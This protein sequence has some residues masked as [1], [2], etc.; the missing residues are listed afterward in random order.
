MSSSLSAHDMHGEQHAL[1][2]GAPAQVNPPFGGYAISPLTRWWRSVAPLALELGGA[3]PHYT[4]AYRTWGR[5]A[6][7]GD[8]AVIVC[9]ALTGTADAD[10][11]WSA[12]FGPG[13]ALDPARDFI[14]CS[15]V[16]GGCYGSTGPAS[17]DVAPELRGARFPELTIRDQ[18]RAQM[19][20]ADALGVRRIRLVIGGSMGGLQ[21]LEW[22]LLDGERVDAIAVVAASA[23]HS[24]WCLA[25]CEIQRLALRA[26]PRFLEGHYT[27]DAMPLA[28]LG[29]ARA[30]AM[31]TYRSPLALEDRFGRNSTAAVY[32]TGATASDDFAVRAWVRHH[33]ENFVRRFD[34]N[35]YLRLLGAMDH[36]D[37]GAGRGGVAAA[38]ARVAQPALV[39]S[40]SSDLLYLPLEQEML[41]DALP[42]ARLLV[43]PS[44]RGHDGFLID[45]DRLEPA[46]RTFRGLEA[47][48][49]T[50]VRHVS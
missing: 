4:L 47:V 16:L 21:T 36:H 22:A 19:A 8:N 34:A 6:P 44:V 37:V 26:D 31:A 2:I 13:K 33:A 27:A 10:D 28:G 41:A 9:H 15:N 7:R 45:A 48:G 40:I 11:W 49:A 43:V 50:G 1:D 35:A 23:R 30:I 20:L 29:T 25:W 38:L 12:L 32:G 46:V 17:A 14:V 5:L 42:N 3:L 24:A 39:V 18:V